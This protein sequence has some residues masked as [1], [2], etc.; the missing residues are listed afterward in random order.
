M[1]MTDDGGPITDLVEIHALSSSRVSSG[2][3]SSAS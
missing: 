3:P 2:R 1:G